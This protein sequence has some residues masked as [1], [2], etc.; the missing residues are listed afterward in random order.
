MTQAIQETA[1][2]QDDEEEY[3]GQPLPREHGKSCKPRVRAPAKTTLRQKAQR[4][5]TAKRG[6]QKMK[7]GGTTAI[8]RPRVGGGFF[9]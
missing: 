5:V 3:P 4:S 8:R 1:F 6:L 9:A 7:Q 2:P